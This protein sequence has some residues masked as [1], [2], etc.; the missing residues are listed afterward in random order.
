M[1]YLSNASALLLFT[2][3]FS[4]NN[5]EVKQERMSNDGSTTSQTIDTLGQ[6][7]NFYDNEE[8]FDLTL[9]KIFVDGEITNPG[10]FIPG[11]MPLRSVIIKETLKTISGDSFLGAYRYDGYSLFDILNDR[12]LDKK[13]AEEFNPITDLFV[14]ISNDQGEKV[15]VSWGELYYPVTLHDILIATKVMRIVPLKTKELWPLPETS[16]LIVAKD[17][18]TERN[19]V[20][21]TK[22]T[23]RSAPVSVPVN[24]ELSSLF[25]PDFKIVDGEQVLETFAQ[26]PSDLQIMNYSTIFYGR[27]RG[28]HSTQPFHGVMLKEMLGKYFPMSKALIQ[29]GA[30]LMIAADGYRCFFT[31][32]EVMNR[33]D[34]SETLVVHDTISQDGGA[35]RLF[36]AGDF[37]SDRAVKALTEIKYITP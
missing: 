28:I 7:N 12:K 25:S 33:N 10:E 35:F 26:F 24:R 5:I 37:F 23:V 20:S 17:L 1:K 14:E 16:K 27:G 11:D 21:P 18:I 6:T 8:T 22:I 15:L 19:L 3:L 30:F 4:C 36:P 2:S 29:Q 9:S 34:Q 13:N 31:Y 32:S